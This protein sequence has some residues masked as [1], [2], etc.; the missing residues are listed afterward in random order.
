MSVFHAIM[1]DRCGRHFEGGD[2]GTDRQPIHDMRVAAKAEG[3]RVGVRGIA[4]HLR[5]VQGTHDF[6]RACVA[7][8]DAEAARLSGGRE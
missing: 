8:W 4:P 7:A 6:C 2:Y 1:C 5:M 3:W